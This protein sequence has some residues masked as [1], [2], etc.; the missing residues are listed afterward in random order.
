VV[1]GS[2]LTLAVWTLMSALWFQPVRANTLAERSVPQEELNDLRDLINSCISA[3]REGDHPKLEEIARNLMIP[4]YETWFTATF[5]E[6]QGTRLTTAYRTNFERDEHWMPKLFEWL[7]KQQGELEVHEANQLP[8]NMANSCGKALMDSEKSNTAFY[9]VDL[10]RKDISGFSTVSSAGYFV[11]VQG[12]FRRLDCKSLGLKATTSGV[13]EV[14]GSSEQAILT[15][16]SHGTPPMRVRIGEND[17]KAKLIEKVQPKYPE[18]ALKNRIAGTV[19]LHVILEK[20][21]TVK[22]L[23]VLSGHPLLSQAAVD[24]VRQWKYRPTLLNGE[25]VEVDTRVDVI[26]ALSVAPKTNP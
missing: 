22:Q 10:R 2:G 12:A 14:G 23:E 4:D 25:P 7:S 19:A 21:G 20:D 17:Q 26:F 8:R 6:E 11:L 13:G 18:E 24:A 15:E 1:T 5:G 3:A 9:R 16:D